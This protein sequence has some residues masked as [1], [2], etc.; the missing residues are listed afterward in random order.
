LAKNVVIY[1]TTSGILRLRSS[2]V[3]VARY[4]RTVPDRLATS[5]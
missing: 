4:V 2:V 5:I 3:V 1:V